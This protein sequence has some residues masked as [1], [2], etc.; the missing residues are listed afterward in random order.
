MY[1]VEC[2]SGGLQNGKLDSPLE[3]FIIIV[4]DENDEPVPYVPVEFRI[5]EGKGRF[6]YNDPRTDQTG[7]AV[8]EFV[9]E[10]PGRFR[11]E[12]FVGEEGRES[13]PFKGIVEAPDPPKAKKP[14]RTKRPSRAAV[15]PVV[16]LT[17]V[18]PI[19]GPP[20]LP[21]EAIPEVPPL[22]PA[23]PPPEAPVAAPAPP[24][25][26]VAQAEP[27]PEA[28]K[29]P[30]ATAQP[31]ATPPKPVAAPVARVASATAVIRRPV[32][33]PAR[34]AAPARAQSDIRPK[35]KKA[36]PKAKVSPVLIAVVAVIYLLLAPLAGAMVAAD[37]S[38]PRPVVDCSRGTWHLEDNV[39][40]FR[41]CVNG[42]R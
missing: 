26:P 4:K 28:P 19:P 29:A 21:A 35:R 14:R 5:A 2:V 10:G 8:A 17:P 37:L 42:A 24:P 40:V 23:P 18:P 27:K 7:S 9:P 39:L 36:A 41:G 16:G 3:P 38:T 12:C 13:I 11:V 32:P 34:A 15:P 30:A 1:K 6:D 33:M 20:P 22:V 31:K 25:P